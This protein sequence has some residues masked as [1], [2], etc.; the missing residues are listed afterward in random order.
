L[1]TALAAPSGRV[2]RELLRRDGEV[3]EGRDDL[4]VELELGFDRAAHGAGGGDLLQEF[5]LL[6]AEV[7]AE[8][9]RDVCVAWRGAVVV[10]DVDADF[11][12][13]PA[14]CGVRT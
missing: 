10:A 3:G 11:A 14:P 12:E 1:A 13:F 8:A 6:W 7:G 9:D 5:E 4:L 2:P